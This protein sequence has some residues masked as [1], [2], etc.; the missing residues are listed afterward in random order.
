LAGG[1]WKKDTTST[2]LPY[3]SSRRFILYSKPA[4]PFVPEKANLI[5]ILQGMSEENQ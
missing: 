4:R 3:N 2:K 1:S 5:L